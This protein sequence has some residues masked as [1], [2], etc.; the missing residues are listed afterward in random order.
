MSYTWF[1]ILA[2]LGHQPLPASTHMATDRRRKG[3]DQSRF[4]TQA[5]PGQGLSMAWYGCRPEAAISL[6][7]PPSYAV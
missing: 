5:D 3:A 6:L 1:F 4:L 2:S 7:M